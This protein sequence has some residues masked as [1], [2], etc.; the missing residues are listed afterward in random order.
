MQFHSTSVSDLPGIAW[1]KHTPV[2][3]RSVKVFKNVPHPKLW[4][5]ANTSNIF[6]YSEMPQDHNLETSKHVMLP[7]I[8]QLLVW[9]P[10]I[11]LR[12]L[13]IKTGMNPLSPIP[14][15]QFKIHC[16]YSFRGLYLWKAHSNP[17]VWINV[18]EFWWLCLIGCLIPPGIP[19]SAADKKPDRWSVKKL[20][21]VP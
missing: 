21:G 14:W 8:L 7:S 13:W 18:F 2:P 17:Q 1:E 15:K 4:Q 20:S 16:C 19:S 3:Y 6:G 9:H 12:L 5:E 11:K 10:T